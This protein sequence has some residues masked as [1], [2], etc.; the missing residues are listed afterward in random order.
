MRV[1]PAE[2]PNLTPVSP[3]RHGTK[4]WRRFT[5]YAFVQAHPLVPIVL[6]EELQVAASL[7]IL[8]APLKDQITPVAVTRLGATTALVAPNGSWRGS[9]VPSILRVHPFA[10]RQTEDGRFAL[11]VD[12]ESG[13]LSNDAADPAFFGVDGEI[14]PELAQVVTFFRSRAQA[15][16]DTRAAMAVLVKTRLLVPAR[17]PE[18]NV[19]Q[20]GLQEI[21]PILLNSLGRID[22][23]E[24]HRTG[25]LGLVYATLV[26]RQHLGFLTAAE[27]RLVSTP[28]PSQMASQASPA[29][30]DAGLGSFF[31]AFASAQ[32]QDHGL[33]NFIRPDQRESS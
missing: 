13:L 19:L 24:L 6:G 30:P 14:S 22:L 32:A 28:A 1:E 2:M 29:G 33:A 8:F 3:E 12:E 11:L 9:Y 20:E 23:T 31:D 16:I 15:E 18:S 4:R 5:S 27:G 7:P 21:D 25:V 10:A 26:A 17:L